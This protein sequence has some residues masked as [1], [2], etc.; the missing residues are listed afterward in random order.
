MLER[1]LTDSLHWMFQNW[2]ELVV[3]AILVK[4]LLVFEHIDQ[5]FGAWAVL[6]VDWMAHKSV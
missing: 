1:I 6:M 3:L 4:G 5:N 2:F